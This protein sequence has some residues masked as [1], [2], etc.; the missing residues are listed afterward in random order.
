MVLTD[1]Q[2]RQR[3][4]FRQDMSFILQDVMS[5]QITLEQKTSSYDANGKYTGQTTESSTINAVISYN[6]QADDELVTAG[7]A[8]VGDARLFVEYDSGLEE[9]DLIIDQSG[10][11]WKVVEI[12]NKPESYGTDTEIHA[13]IRRTEAR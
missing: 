1:R 4:K 3:D 5:Q 7:R 11:R 10:D 9:E 8:K 6:M 12:Y 13:I 2:T